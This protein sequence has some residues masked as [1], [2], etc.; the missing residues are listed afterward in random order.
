MGPGVD[1]RLGPERCGDWAKYGLQSPCGLGSGPGVVWQL[2]AAQ[3]EVCVRSA[4]R[5]GPIAVWRMDL[6]W[7]GHCA[8]CA[9]ETCPVRPEDQDQHGMELSRV[10]IL[11][12]QPSAFWKLVPLLSGHWE[13]CT[14]ETGHSAVRRLSPGCMATE[15]VVAWRLTPCGLETS[16]GTAW[17]L[18][19]AWSGNCA[20]WRLG[21]A[22]PGDCAWCSVETCL[23]VSCRLGLVWSA[24]WAQSAVGTGP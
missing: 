13:Q 18:D 23:G 3:S 15:P 24:D 20:T 2:C 10:R 4:W 22:Q 7:C 17:R 9:V 19:L 14:Y 12:T 1:W 8:W 11:V 16:R 21:P 5:L 6:M